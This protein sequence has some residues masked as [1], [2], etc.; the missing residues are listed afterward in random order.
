MPREALAARYTAANDQAPIEGRAGRDEARHDEVE[1]RGIAV[2][3]ALGTCHRRDAA[4]KR[5]EREH[6][7][8]KHRQ[9]LEATDRALRPN[10]RHPAGRDQI[11]GEGT[12]D[13]RPQVGLGGGERRAER[14]HHEHGDE[15]YVPGLPVPAG[16]LAK[17]H[18]ARAPDECDRSHADVDEG[19]G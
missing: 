8:R 9:P 3:S 18:R 1:A 10:D 7:A 16:S 14:G 11:E 15:E 12:H 2:Q 17:A 6:G 13:G 19:Q 4:G 5:R